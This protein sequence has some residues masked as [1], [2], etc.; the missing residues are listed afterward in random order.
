LETKVIQ[1]SLLGFDRGGTKSVP[2]ASAIR[3]ES[4]DVVQQFCEKKKKRQG[5]RRICG[6]CTVPAAVRG[7]V[8]AVAAAKVDRKHA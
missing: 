5:D 3:L 2:I 7:R 8:P 6:P 1:Q 4:V